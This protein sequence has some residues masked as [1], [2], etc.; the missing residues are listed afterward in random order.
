MPALPEE[1]SSKRRPPASCPS[2][3]ACLIINA[4]ERS[5]SDPPGLP[6]SSLPKSLV[7]GAASATKSS[8]I[9]G[10]LPIAAMISGITAFLAARRVMPSVNCFAGILGVLVLKIII[11]D[12]E[13]ITGDEKVFLP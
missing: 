2:S 10:V 4:T 8:S 5:F 11:G 3:T 1:E 7:P 13:V 6:L 9:N 12:R